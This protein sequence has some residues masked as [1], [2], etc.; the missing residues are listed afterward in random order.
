ME[1]VNG[2]ASTGKGAETIEFEDITLVDAGQTFV[3]HTVVEGAELF[4]ETVAEPSSR[5]L[6][7][8]ALKAWKCGHCNCG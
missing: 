4:F 2:Y 3:Y 7:D 5:E 8:A 1:G 6:L